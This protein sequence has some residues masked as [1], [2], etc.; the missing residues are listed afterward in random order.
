MPHWE[1]HTI[2]A[3]KHAHRVEIEELSFQFPKPLPNSAKEIPHII[4]KCMK[5]QHYV[6]NFSLPS[7]EEIN[8]HS[9]WNYTS[10]SITIISWLQL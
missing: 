1:E 7:F 6:F 3:H 9:Y 10:W 8:Q 4:G 2:H 5:L